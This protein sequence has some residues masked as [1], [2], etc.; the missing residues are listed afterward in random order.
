M[1]SFAS[2]LTHPSV[3]RK[4]PLSNLHVNENPSICALADAVAPSFPSRMPPEMDAE[5][6]SPWTPPSPNAKI[7]RH[8]AGW[9]GS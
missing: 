6:S 1:A 2:T 8:G 9:T 3:R 5:H 7:D 4:V